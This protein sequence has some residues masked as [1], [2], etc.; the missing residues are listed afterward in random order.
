MRFSADR[1]TRSCGMINRVVVI[2]AFAAVGAT[3]LLSAATFTV[4]TN[5]DSGAG[6]CV[7]PSTTPTPLPALTR[8]PSPSRPG[9]APP[10]VCARSL[11]RLRCRR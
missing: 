5:A 2:V 6:H 9:N 10:R 7:K 3:P 11:S 8:S 4:T 1:D